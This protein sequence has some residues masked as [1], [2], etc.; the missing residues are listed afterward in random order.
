M[1]IVYAGSTLHFIFAGM[2][3][4]A[5]ALYVVENF[6][7]LLLAIVIGRNLLKHRGAL[8]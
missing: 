8:K 6:T 7:L 4:V 2:L 5:F 1:A 3:S